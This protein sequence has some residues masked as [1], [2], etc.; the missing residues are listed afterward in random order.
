MSCGAGVGHLA[1]AR[2]VELVAELLEG[3]VVRV[4]AGYTG[5][6]VRRSGALDVTAEGIAFEPH[7]SERLLWARD[8][9]IPAC[10]IV[11]VDVQPPR[12][13]LPGTPG[14]RRLCVVTADQTVH[15]F[16]VGLADQVSERVRAILSSQTIDED[17]QRR[18]EKKLRRS[19]SSAL[20]T[21]VSAVAVVSLLWNLA[22]V[23]IGDRDFGVAELLSAGFVGLV[24]LAVAAVY[25]WDRRR[26]SGS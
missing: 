22:P 3:E 8:L 23:A 21:V 16:T 1:G 9:W 20:L 15:L 14:V 26:E 24:L 11:A 2:A 4:A 6:W 25:F 18:F 7:H 5:G 10:E 13:R 19:S 12:L 17:E